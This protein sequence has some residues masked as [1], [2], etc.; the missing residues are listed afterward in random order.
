MQ[1]ASRELIYNFHSPQNPPQFTVKQGEVFLA[2]TELCTGGW[3]LSYEDSWTPDKTCALNPTVCVAV[4]GAAPGDVLAVRIHDVVPAEVGY[5]G[6]NKD[7]NHLAN[8]V[9]VNDWGMNVKTVKIEDGFVLWDEKRKLP[10]APMIGTLGTAPA[11]ETLSNAKAGTHGGNMD[12]QEVC[13]GSTVYLPVAVDGGIL[14]I[15]DCHAIQGDGEINCS[16]GI[17]CRAVCKISI[18]VI[19]CP[20][21]YGG[22]RIE[23]DDY[24]MTVASEG[25]TKEAFLEAT[26]Q[27]VLWMAADYGFNVNEAYLLLGQVMEAR[28]T[29]Y[30]NPTQSY[31]CKMPKKYL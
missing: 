29:Q 2:E 12:V 26:K 27:L 14:H 23:N 11:E 25:S 22:V 3:L 5:T 20:A 31:I 13:P 17:E 7:S 10:I 28:A 6:F 1:K 15:G 8:K 9:M 21:N 24:I 30:V 18:D 16:G 19:K 4:E